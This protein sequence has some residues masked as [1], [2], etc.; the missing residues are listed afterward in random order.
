MPV[1]CCKAQA[2]NPTRCAGQ[3]RAIIVV[4]RLVPCFRPVRNLLSSSALIAAVL[5]AAVLLAAAGCVTQDRPECAAPAVTIDLA[6]RD[7]A[8]EPTDP[9]ACRGQEVTLHVTADEALVLHIHGYDA[10]ATELAEGVPADI[11]FRAERSGQF[12]IEIHPETDPAGVA[13]G[14]LTIHEP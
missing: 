14:I 8:V 13:V 1:P 9:A 6:I 12:T 3:A 4:T 5:L 10:Q 11:T 2:N 7:R